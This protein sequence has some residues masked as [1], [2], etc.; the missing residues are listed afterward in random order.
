MKTQKPETIGQCEICGRDMV[1]GPSV[2]N[3][4]WI[5]RLKGGKDGPQSVIHRICHDKLHSIWSE[6]ELARKFNNAA[7]IREADEMADFLKFLRN[8]SPDFY[9]HTK[10]NNRRR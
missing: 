10:L 3:H 1:A 9:T 5:P 8:K 4:H 2:N 7:I 6:V